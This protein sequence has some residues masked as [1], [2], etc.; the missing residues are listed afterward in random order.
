MSR[1]PA[2]YRQLT[3]QEYQLLRDCFRGGNTHANRYYSGKIVDSKMIHARILSFDRSSL[4]Q[5]RTIR[6]DYEHRIHRQ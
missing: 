1:V 4:Y 6:G 5:L 3:Y 2:P